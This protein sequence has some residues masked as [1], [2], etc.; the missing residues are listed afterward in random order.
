MN[1]QNGASENYPCADTAL[2]VPLKRSALY[3]SIRKRVADLKPVDSWQEDGVHY[4]VFQ[5]KPDGE[6]AAAS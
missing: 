2:L 3:G 6:A 1:N 4:F 5:L